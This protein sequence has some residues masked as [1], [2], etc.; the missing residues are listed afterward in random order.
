VLL[1][2]IAVAA[3]HE[4]LDDLRALA[5]AHPGQGGTDEIE[6]AV[7]VRRAELDRASR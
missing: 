1:R 6:R 3:S 5:L 7:K 2:A 4:E